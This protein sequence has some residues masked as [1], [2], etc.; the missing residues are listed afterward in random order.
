VK[1]VGPRKPTPHHPSRSSSRPIRELL[2]ESPFRVMIAT[3][4]DHT[5]VLVMGHPLPP[6]GPVVHEALLNEVQGLVHR[7]PDKGGVTAIEVWAP[8]R[9]GEPHSI[10][11]REVLATPVRLSLRPVSNPYA[12]M[13]GYLRSGGTFASSMRHPSVAGMNATESGTTSQQIDDLFVPPPLRSLLAGHALGSHRALAAFVSEL[14]ND[15]AFSTRPIA[16]TPNGHDFEATLAGA[17][18]FVR[19]FHSEKRVPTAVVDRFGYGFLRSH[20]DEALF[21]SDGSITYDVRHWEGD[22]R[23]HLIGRLGL[24]RLVN[25]VAAR[26]LRT[27]AESQAG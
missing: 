17:R 24:Q 1:R 4:S 3:I 12:A 7:N 9:P 10:V 25:A 19:C 18:V 21:V 15:A 2:K 8:V 22:S 20:Y 5:A 27:A 13:R 26:H 23:I 6:V 16:D 14:L 11:H